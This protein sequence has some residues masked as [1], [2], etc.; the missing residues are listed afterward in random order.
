MNDRHVL[1]EAR[2]RSLD[3]LVSVITPA[4]NA[5]RVIERAVHSVAAQSVATLEHIV[6]DDGSTDDTRAMLRSLQPDFP[7][8]HVIV[9]PHEGA[10]QARNA[11]IEAARGRYVAFLDA[12][13]EWL[14]GKLARQVKF[15]ESEGVL[16]SY[17]D[18]QCDRSIV[19]R[20]R[21]KVHSPDQIGYEDF[22]RACPIGCLTVAYNQ[23]ALGKVYMPEVERGHD[24]GLWLRL[25][26]NGVVARRYP[27]IEAIYHV[28]NKSLSGKKLK[29]ARDV[30]RIYRDQERI[31]R[32]R[33]LV[34]LAEHSLRSFF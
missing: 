12:D 21:R 20:D 18:Y 33:S 30:Y 13:D 3:H 29:K 19:G 9:K 17:G 11:G 14:P 27:G 4:Y 2:G 26:R 6:I 1:P 25:T 23:E 32:T 15:M 10:A 34:Y 31:G 24:W 7:D 28:S 16:F 8:L 5:A 22:L